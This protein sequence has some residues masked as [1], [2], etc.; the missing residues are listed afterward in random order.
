MRTWLSAAVLAVI[1]VLVVLAAAGFPHF[2]EPRRHIAGFWAGDPAFLR[3]AGL[4][5]MFLML[6][7]PARAGFGS[8]SCDGYLFMSTAD[9]VVCNQAV[10]MRFGGLGAVRRKHVYEGRAVLTPHDHEACPLGTEYDAVRDG[11]AASM[12]YS[13]SPCAGSLALK[14][15]GELRA[16]LF[17]DCGASTAAL[18]SADD[19]D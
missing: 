8:A 6:H 15:D 11:Y 9:G 12:E 17:K 2:G 1:V 7:E 10:S 4:V 14:Q 3:E 18:A 16:F 5:D 13:L 19:A